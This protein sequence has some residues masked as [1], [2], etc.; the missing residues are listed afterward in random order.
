MTLKKR[1]TTGAIHRSARTKAQKGF[2]YP[3]RGIV[4]LRVTFVTIINHLRWKRFWDKNFSSEDSD[5]IHQTTD[6]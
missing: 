1:L 4:F 3:L 5:G 2:V 6:E